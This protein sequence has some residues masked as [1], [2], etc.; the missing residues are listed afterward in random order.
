M[1]HEWCKLRGSTASALQNDNRI[2]IEADQ[3][4]RDFAA[5]AA[6]GV[7]ITKAK[8]SGCSGCSHG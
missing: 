2:K 1:R 3:V 7:T 5:V 6:T 8:A 4:L